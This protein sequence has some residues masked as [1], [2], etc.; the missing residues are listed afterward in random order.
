M[1]PER[2]QCIHNSTMSPMICN[3]ILKKMF[4]A[5]D[6][7]RWTPKLISTA[8]ITSVR[9]RIRRRQTGVLAKKDFKT[10]KNN[11]VWFPVQGCIL[12]WTINPVN[13]CYQTSRRMVLVNMFR[14]PSNSM[15]RSV[16]PWSTLNLVLLAQELILLP[17]IL[18]I[19]NSSAAPQ[20]S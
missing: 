18:V 14:T 4:Q 13:T 12:L 17:V 9:Q 7:T 3:K 15:D 6:H 11:Q 19:S 10:N 20:L 16:C 1:N 2:P 5:P 8:Y